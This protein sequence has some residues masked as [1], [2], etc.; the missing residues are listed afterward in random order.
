MVSSLYGV[1]DIW[2]SLFPRSNTLDQV[3]YTVHVLTEY[4]TKLKE[5][6]KQLQATP[7]HHHARQKPFMS[8]NLSH[9]TH[10]FVWQDAV[11]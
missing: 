10:V 4:V 1:E 5:T 8:S 9:W 7:T 11:Q 2:V 3:T 6:I